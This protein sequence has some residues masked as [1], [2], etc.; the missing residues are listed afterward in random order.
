MIISV[1]R[2]SDNQIVLHD[3]TDKVSRYHAD[4]NIK[5]NGEITIV[6]KSTNGTFVNGKQI[7]KGIEIKVQKEDKI[8]FANVSIL[9]WQNIPL[10]KED[11]TFRRQ[12]RIGTANDN[13]IVLFDPNQKIS[14][15]HAILVIDKKS[16]IYIKDISTNGTFVNGVRI[17]SNVDFPVSRKD[18]IIFAK[19]QP[20]NWATVE[21]NKIPARSK[22][23]IYG[24]LG[25]L[26]CIILVIT[27]KS[28]LSIDI[29]KKYNTSVVL[30]YHEYIYEVEITGRDTY[31]L[32][33]DEDGDFIEYDPDYSGLF[34]TGTGF[35]V[36]NDGIVVTNRHVVSPWEYNDE[37]DELKQVIHRIMSYR[38]SINQIKVT[39]MT[40]S[41]GFALNN[42]FLA[43]TDDLFECD[44]HK[45]S[46]DPRIDLASIQTE[47][48]TLPPTVKEIVNLNSALTNP[49]HLKLGMKLYMLGFPAGFTL[50]ATDKGLKAN[51]Q[52]GQLSREPDNYSI[53]HNL[54][55]M[56][57]GSGSPI[58]DKRGRIVAVNYAMFKNSQGF[59]F[60]ILSQ[61]IN[62]VVGY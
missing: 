42:S 54:P 34:I 12:Y 35:F 15:Y 57:G 20:L 59:N 30:I 16:H 38:Y 55:T 27:V 43:S 24:T 62:E 4:L 29:A 32:A 8:S 2:A 21:F 50:G 49:Q 10:P 7:P 60:G 36:S 52:A 47:T 13:D 25:I 1:G 14:R 46:S 6:D 39:P 45:K 26:A 9:N 5:D 37:V 22:S 18:T 33:K 51:F 23:Y 17:S 61:Y 56:G 58:F 3:P 31:Y 44:V 53:G 11:S 41:M 40:V 19:S 28:F 48:K